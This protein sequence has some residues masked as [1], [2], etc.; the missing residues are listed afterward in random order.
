MPGSVENE[1]QAIGQPNTQAVYRFGS[2]GTPHQNADSDLDVAVLLPY[3]MVRSVDPWDWVRL[4]GELTGVAQN[5]R[6]DLVNLEIATTALQAEILRTGD[7]VYSAND[8][9]RLRFELP[10]LSKYRELCRWRKPLLEKL[11]SGN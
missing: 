9:A 6:V 7:L 3:D 8:N 10:V 11:L 4:N 5:D 1:A 2:W